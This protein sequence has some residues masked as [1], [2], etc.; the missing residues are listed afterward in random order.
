MIPYLFSEESV[1]NVINTAKDTHNDFSS[2]QN[3]AEGLYSSIYQAGESLVATQCISLSFS[4]PVG[5]KV[6]ACWSIK[7]IAPIPVG[8]K[9]CIYFDEKEIYCKSFG[10]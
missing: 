6:S 10:L 2:Q 8:V 5:A 3:N 4:P 9:V 7:T 1:Q